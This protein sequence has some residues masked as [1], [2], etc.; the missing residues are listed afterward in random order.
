[1]R[2]TT[3]ASNLFRRALCPG[4]ARM[5]A[6]LPDEDTAQSREG[7][8]LHDYAAHPE[9]DRAMLKPNQ[10]DLLSTSDELT[11]QVIDRVE[12]ANDLVGKTQGDLYEHSFKGEVP[13]T[14]DIVRSYPSDLMIIDRKFGY[15]VVEHADLN[16]QLRAYAVL[17]WFHGINNSFVA[18]VQPRAPFEERIT[19]AK[20]TPEDIEDSRE[21]IKSIV[22]ASEKEDAPLIAGE[23]QCR[24]CKAKLICSA[25]R[26]AMMVPAV[27]EPSA[28]AA[29]LSKTAK[30]AYLERRLAECTDEQLEKTITAIRLADFAHDIVYDEARKRIKNGKFENYTL[31]KATSVREVTNVRRAL[32]LLSLAGMN[33]DD[34]YDCVTKFSLKELEDKVRK[35][36]P[37]WPWKQCREF[38]DERL[39]SVIELQ[40]RKERILRK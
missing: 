30:E 5:E 8:L 16:L 32:A 20:Y 14:P 38:V 24:Y 21:Q 18:I 40:T 39:S 1:M 27:F 3:T 29:D 6:G 4:S 34:V 17:T 22:R 11:N 35:L 2:P 7:T 28:L 25:F 23:E 26:E 19:I 10:R 37:T 36:H 15:N 31:G 33:R 13:G 12:L 9:Y